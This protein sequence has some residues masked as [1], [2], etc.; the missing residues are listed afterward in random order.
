LPKL[1]HWW[2][3]LTPDDR[4]KII[5][6][7]VTALITLTATTIVPKVVWPLVTHSLRAAKEFIYRRFAGYG[8]FHRWARGRYESTLRGILERV[9]NPWS[10]ER[11][12]MG[13]LFV[14]IKVNDKFQIPHFIPGTKQPEQVVTLR[15]AAEKYSFFVLVGDPGG[16]KTTALKSLGLGALDGRLYGPGEDIMPVLVELRR[17]ASSQ[18]SLADYVPMVFRECGFPNA[19]SFVRRKLQRHKIL[20]LLDGLDEVGDLRLSEVLNAIR[21]FS[22]QYPH[23]HVVLT[24]RV[25]SYDRQLDDVS[26][27]TIALTPFN[28][29]QIAAYLRHRSFPPAKSALQLMTILRERPQ[30]RT[31]CRNPLLLTIVTSLYAETDYVLPSSRSEFYSTCVEALLKRWD[32]TRQVDRKNRF[33]VSTKARILEK[34]ALRLQERPDPAADVAEQELIDYVAQILPDIGLA[35]DLADEVIREV[36]RNTGLLMY[37]A[38]TRLRFTHLTFQEFFAGRE[39]DSRA[40]PNTLFEH[41]QSNHAHWREVTILFC[42]ISRSAREVIQLI[43]PRDPQMAAGCIAEAEGVPISLAQSVLAGLQRIAQSGSHAAEAL[44]AASMMAVNERVPW[45]GAA[46]RIVRAGISSPDK[47]VA[48]AS[49]WALANIPTDEAAAELV[50]ALQREETCELAKDALKQMGSPALPALQAVLR[51][52]ADA[53]TRVM[54]L[55]LCAYVATPEVID[56]LVPVLLDQAR[57]VSERTAAARSLGT[58]LRDSTIEEGLRLTKA[59]DTGMNPTSAERLLMRGEKRAWPFREEPDAALP[60]I[61]QAVVDQ[62][63][64][65]ISQ[66]RQAESVDPRIAIPLFIR[67]IESDARS[68]RRRCFSELFGPLVVD[69]NITHTHTHLAGTPYSYDIDRSRPDSLWKQWAAIED[70]L[71]IIRMRGH[72]AKRNCWISVLEMARVLQAGSEVI[73]GNQS[74]VRTV[75]PNAPSISLKVRQQLVSRFRSRRQSSDKPGPPDQTRI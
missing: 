32:Y 11:Q 31:I 59:A 8:L 74:P 71:R 36:V 34:V 65:Y 38:P 41:L 66:S 44:K 12:V 58:L 39:L 27:A 53:P 21:D 56:V 10:S 5:V 54:C 24:C 72:P 28:D 57:P 60:L 17:Y 9:A 29:I 16:G 67:T 20:L 3:S 23:N 55:E 7:A 6:A 42:G 63:A 14:P 49:I 46:F 64:P 43:A 68:D 73:G 35:A 33:A 45:S 2:N 18:L 19:D 75:F 51:S 25:A 50:G 37:V 48:S 30:I 26:E 70:D 15:D 61:A 22:N 13:R 40:D 52:N 69:E 4:S 47:E 62:L 1:L